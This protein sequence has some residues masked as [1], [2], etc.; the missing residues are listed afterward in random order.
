ML[1]RVAAQALLKGTYTSL[2]RAHH[3]I[4]LLLLSLLLLL[5]L[6]LYGDVPSGHAS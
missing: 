3:R 6:L 4:L 5:L 1:C 2:M